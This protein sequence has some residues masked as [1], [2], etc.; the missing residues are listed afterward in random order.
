MNS[1]TLLL[2]IDTT[3]PK[4]SVAFLRGSRILSEVDWDTEDS[5]T[6]WI[7]PKIREARAEAQVGKEEVEAL[8][9]LRGPGSFT[10][11]RIGLG[12]VMGL[13]EVSQ[14]PIYPIG[15]LEAIA[16][17]CSPR[18]SP[19]QAVLDAG[20]NQVYVQSFLRGEGNLIPLDT[21]VCWEAAAWLSSLSRSDL[22][23]CGRGAEK[24]RDRIRLFFPED[25]ILPVPRNLAVQAGLLAGQWSAERKIES[26]EIPEALYIR[27]PD[28]F[29]TAK[30]PEK[31]NG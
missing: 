16:Y 13:A 21:P 6:E 4:G 10:G 9:I 18:S 27:P 31:Q 15:T 30:N 7:L 2:S 17:G 20:R 8:V 29:R 28:V 1:Q 24:Y 14:I 22:Y 19:L 3:S 5:H 25:P 11:I 23:F 12:I 26:I